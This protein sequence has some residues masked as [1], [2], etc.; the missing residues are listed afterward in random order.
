FV[1]KVVDNPKREDVDLTINE[2]L[3]VELYSK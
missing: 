1:G 2:Q 3:I